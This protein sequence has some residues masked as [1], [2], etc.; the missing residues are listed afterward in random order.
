MTEEKYTFPKDIC[1]YCK[2]ERHY[3]LYAAAHWDVLL[4][5]TCEKCGKLYSVLRGRAIKRKQKKIR[6][7]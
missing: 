5:T 3:S 4:D 2:N 7:N 1:P 6:G